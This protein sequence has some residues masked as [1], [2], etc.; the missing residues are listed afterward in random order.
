MRERIGP[1]VWRMLHQY[2]IPTVYIL[3]LWHTFAYGSD[4]KGHTPL[5]AALWIMQAPLVVLYPWRVWLGWRSRGAAR[6]ASPQGGA[7]RAE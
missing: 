1:A 7:S 5:V 2:L 3:A 6:N 4:A